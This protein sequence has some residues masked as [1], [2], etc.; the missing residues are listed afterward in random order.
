MAVLL[1]A[2]V[3][4]VV[5]VR[6]SSADE[7][8][9]GLPAEAESSKQSLVAGTN[10]GM[11]INAGTVI[12][13]SAVATSLGST[14]NVHLRT[15]HS[16]LDPPTD[17]RDQEL[18]W[19][20]GFTQADRVRSVGLL[21][22]A[23]QAAESISEDYSRVSALTNIARVLAPIDSA[24]ALL[25]V[26]EAERIASN[27]PN[28]MMTS[29][30]VEA[31]AVIDPNRAENIAQYMTSGIWKSRAHAYIALALAD[32]D[33]NRAQRIAESITD[34]I[35]QSWTFTG[36]A[37]ALATKNLGRAERIIQSIVDEDEKVTALTSIAGMIASTEEE[38]A[39][40]LIADAEHTAELLGNTKGHALIQIA[41]A[42][43]FVNPVRAEAIAKSIPIGF[44][45]VEAL[46]EIAKVL[47]RTDPC[48]ARRLISNAEVIVE[49]MG[50]FKD[51][52]IASIA[53][54]LAVIDP[55]RVERIAET[56]IA[57]GPVHGSIVKIVETLAVSNPDHATRLA[58]SVTDESEKAELL[59][60]I[61]EARNCSE[62]SS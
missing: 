44:Q 53:P 5:Q 48:T 28:N 3:V 16:D 59:V 51:D 24:R 33:P 30:I 39:V 49:G 15:T 41:R 54:A 29:D 10:T 2:V 52:G 18:R 55:D 17:N 13:G 19:D 32:T 62:K 21:I 20:P 37:E 60:A 6:S 31:V 4:A 57:K 35:V 38:S 50:N 46:A 9:S 36:I 56:I 45:R 40:W 58:R 22:E 14:A 26:G 61:V 42:L 27:N 34:E 1:V 11:M 43:S 8:A 7:G 23:K 12:V 25:I 47:A